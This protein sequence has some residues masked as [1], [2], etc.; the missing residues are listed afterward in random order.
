MVVGCYGNRPYLVSGR[1]PEVPHVLREVKTSH[2]QDWIR[3]VKECMVDPDNF[4]RSNSDFS[5]AGP[6]VEMVDLGV[7]AV[8]LQALNQILD[9]DGQNMKFTNIPADA[10]IKFQ[11]HDGFTIKDGHPTFNKTYSDPVNA[12][13][14]AASL[15]KR[16]YRAGYVLPDMPE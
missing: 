7:A 9:W 12:R 16:E 15:I 3:A 2:Q 10:T 11:I 13:E 4:T 14:F 1:K 6:F 5:M 8:R